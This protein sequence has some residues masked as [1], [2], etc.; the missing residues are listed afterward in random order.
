MSKTVELK[1][2][3]TNEIQRKKLASSI[4]KNVIRIGNKMIAWV[5]VELLN[6][7]EYQRSR[8]RHVT[9]IAEKSVPVARAIIKRDGEEGLSF[10]FS[11]I[12]ESHWDNYKEG[13]GSDLMT[14][15]GK[16]YFTHK[17]ELKVIKSRLCGFFSQSNPNELE[18][19]GNNNYPNLTRRARLD[20]ILADIVKEPEPPKK[21]SKK[22]TKIA[23]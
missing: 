10:V 11:V 1:P 12:K 14:A 8:Q 22:V 7:K 16:V 21:E 9:Q 6:I 18:A 4:M 17:H 13:Y 23:S 3:L 20:A 15:L 19:L 2:T 5:P